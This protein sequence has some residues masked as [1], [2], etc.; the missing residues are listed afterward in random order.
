MDAIVVEDL[1]KRYKAIQAVDGVSLSVKE[2]EV[3]VEPTE[4][5]GPPPSFE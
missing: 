3:H 4:D 2:G 1:H 5:L